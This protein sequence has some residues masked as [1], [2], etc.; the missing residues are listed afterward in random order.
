MSQINGNPGSSGPV[1]GDGTAAAAAGMNML[2]MVIVIAVVI[3]LAVLA[4]GALAGGWFSSGTTN[5][6]GNTN[7][8]T[9]QP[10]GAAPKTSAPAAAP[11][12]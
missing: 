3:V 8:T 12:R 6:A 9:Q 5:T 1:R 4:Y 7:V 10:Q 11:S 2:V